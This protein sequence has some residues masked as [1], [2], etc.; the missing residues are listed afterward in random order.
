MAGVYIAY[1]FCAQKC[2]YCNFASG[3]LP[4]GLEREY[5]RTVA[6]ELRAHS[7]QWTPETIYLGGGTPSAMA[8][9]DLSDLLSL[10]P[11]RPW[12]E[13]TIEAAPGTVT[14]ERAGVWAACGIT[15]VS[16]GVQSF[17]ETEIRRTGRKHT[18]AV[19]ERELAIL[20]ECG[21]TNCNI[22][23]IAGLAGQTAS[24][25]NESLDWIE[26]LKPPHVS[27]YMLEIDE[28]SRLGKELL[29]G[30]IRYGAADVPTDDETASFY[31]TAVERL[32]SLRM[33]RY[34]ISNFARPG[35]E[36]R[37]NLKY[38]R[39][40]PYVGFGADAHSF[41]GRFRKQNPE[42]VRDYLDGRPTASSPANIGEERF[43]VGLRLTDGIRPQPEEWRRY[44]APISRFVADGLLEADGDVLRLTRRGVL[45]SNE[46]FQEFL[47]P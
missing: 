32:A 3:V 16:L 29:L 33:S 6:C 31:E 42:T 46:V 10:I 28:D 27:V 17:V 25:W 35:S 7:W 2:T 39:L 8:I 30:G 13:A 47:L 26:R 36:S 44:E 38:W 34:E 23:L 24:S 12:R 37:H 45:L 11:G 18:A 21:I 15:R 22:D 5:I 4:A 14:P 20:R 1:P 9:E 43:F 41:D 19:V 40:E